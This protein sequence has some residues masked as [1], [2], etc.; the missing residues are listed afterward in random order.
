VSCDVLSLEWSSAGRDIEIVEPVLCHLEMTQGLVVRRESIL[1]AAAVIADAKPGVLLMSNQGGATPNFRAVRFAAQFGVPVVTLVSEGMFPDDRQTVQR[2]W[3]GNNTDEVCYENLNLQW[4]QRSV[5]LIRRY[6]PGAEEFP[7]AVS[8]ATGFDRYRLF[9][10]A[11]REEMLQRLGRPGF[12]RIVGFAGWTFCHVLGSYYERNRAAVDIVLGGHDA[13]E[14]HARQLPELRAVLSE[15]VNANPEVLFVLKEH[16]GLTDAEFSEFSE[17]DDRPNVV[18]IRATGA[19]SEINVS[20]LIGA[21]DLWLAYES[22]TTLEAWMLDTPTALVNPLGD[23]KRSRVAG[24]S[25]MF[26]TAAQVQAAI[27]AVREDMPV[28]GFDE[29]AESRR[30]LEAEVIGYSDGANH[31]RAADRVLE[32]LHDPG[33]VHPSALG[34]DARAELA[35]A[36][37][38]RMLERLGV[39]RLPRYR[40]LREERARM[41]AKYDPAERE[42]IRQRYTE[43]LE[44]FHGSEAGA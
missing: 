16:P 40:R 13:A 21:S 2:M 24:G 17:L 22:T 34:E 1:D 31:V 29:L 41:R 28:P 37:R 43:A 26:S 39:L 11:T 8:G 42:R 3:W 36:R 32:V 10:W 4:S 33:A 5:D 23:F 44:R 30:E 9:D 20:D 6:V 38:T 14:K 7:I 25:P 15:A 12:S 35:R 19:G 18:V 27:D